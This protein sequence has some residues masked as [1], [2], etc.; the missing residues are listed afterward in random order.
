MKCPGSGGKQTF[1]KEV[2]LLNGLDHRIVVKVMKVSQPPQDEKY[3]IDRATVWYDL[4]KV[5][6][7]FTNFDRNK[8]LSLQEAGQTLRRRH[9]R[10]TDVQ[11]VNLKVRQATALEE[12]DA[13]VAAGMEESFKLK[14]SV[15]SPSNDGTNAC[16]FLSVGVAESILKQHRNRG[17][18]RKFTES[19]GGYHSVFTGG[20]QRAPRHGKDLRHT[21]SI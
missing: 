3:E 7:G 20:N 18:F 12:F 14:E 11:V 5:Y 15:T 19:C 8:R 6:R 1:L 21:R 16:A 13:R 17:F 4:E 10:S 2:A 9:E